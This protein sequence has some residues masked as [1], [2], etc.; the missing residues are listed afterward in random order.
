MSSWQIQHYANIIMIYRPTGVYY[1]VSADC[2]LE[3]TMRRLA[4]LL[5]GDQHLFFGEIWFSMNVRLVGIKDV[6]N[7]TFV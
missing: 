6:F 3:M 4:T 7:Y 5:A 1:T 2:Q